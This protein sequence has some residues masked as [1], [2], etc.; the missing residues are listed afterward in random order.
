ME[1]VNIY[2]LNKNETTLKLFMR[3]LKSTKQDFELH[4]ITNKDEIKD[5]K[6]FILD[7]NQDIK[8]NIVQWSIYQNEGFESHLTSL[9]KIPRKSNFF[10][11]KQVKNYL[12]T[13]PD[14][15]SV[16]SFNIFTSE[17]YNLEVTLFIVIFLII[18][19]FLFIIPIYI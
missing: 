3:F 10:I 18:A 19:I 15:K 11:N 4:S 2:V 9:E 6:Y 1:K 7:L 16:N 12:K 8:R 5:E 17:N 14:L 13:Q